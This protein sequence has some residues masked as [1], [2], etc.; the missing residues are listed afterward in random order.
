MRI[1]VL[2]TGVVGQTLGRKLVDLGHEVT[3]GSRQAGNEKAV[4]WVVSAGGTAVGGTAAE[5]SFADAASTADMV[6][7]ATSG[8]GSLEALDAAGAGNLA[9]K[10]L[11]DVSNPLDFSRGMP[12]SLSVCN[13]DSLAEQIQRRF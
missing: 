1:A 2:G 10:V 9:G 7:N 11:I 13:T 4:A 8:V 6:V 12:P 3:M 5:G